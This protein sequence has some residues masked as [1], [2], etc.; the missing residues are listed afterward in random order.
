VSS[1]V[2]VKFAD[3]TLVRSFEGQKA[4]LPS[5]SLLDPASNMHSWQAAPG[6]HESQSHPSGKKPA[7][8]DTSAN[9]HL[10]PCSCILQEVPVAIG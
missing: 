8:R 6:Q 10:R 1:A 3:D 7:G 2:S 9:T 5:L 4:K